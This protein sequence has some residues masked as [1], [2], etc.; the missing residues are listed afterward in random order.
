M[1]FLRKMFSGRVQTQDPRRYVIEAM[2]GAM[3]ADGD[4]TEDEMASLQGNLEGHELFAGLTRDEVSR[5]VDLAADAIREAGGGQAR[6]PEIA[7]GLPSR[8]QRLTAYGMACE[9][10]VSDRELAEAEID[11]LDALQSALGLDEGEAKEVF[12]A[13]RAHSGLLTLEEKTSKMKAIMPRFVDCMALMAAADG[14][15]HHQ[16][17]LGIRAVL[18]NIP[19]MAVLTGDELD[20]TIE[21]S[22]DKVSGSD[23]EAELA[24]IAKVIATPADRYWTTVYMMII[25][26]ADG[27]SDWREVSFLETAK[28]TFELTD[29]QMD[30]A[31]DTARQFPAVELGGEVPE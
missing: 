8:T 17:R 14:E 21:A 7:K 25:A 19:D 4:V 3:E 23:V 28:S 20:Q 12:E 2:L 24:S 10:C 26:L 22:L 9:V 13:A 29:Y 5:F 6:L 1:S 16:E 11:Y 27:N 30:V 15:I 31:M 18:R